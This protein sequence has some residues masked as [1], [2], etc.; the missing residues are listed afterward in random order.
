M[1]KGAKIIIGVLVLL[2][3]AVLGFNATREKEGDS[4]GEAPRIDPTKLPA[5]SM[6]EWGAEVTSPV[7]IAGTAPG[8]WYFEA[9]FPIELITKD[10]ELLG[11]GIA[12]AT[13]EWMT[14]APVKF[15]TSIPFVVSKRTEA[16]LVLK[17]DNP[18]GLPE[19][20]ASFKVPIALLP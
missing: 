19:N 6:P 12:Q 13:E 20:D 16:F 10:G 8:P 9:S 17:K 5:L 15:T 1:N 11:T 14:V 3:I 4:F 18:S 7:N 2:V